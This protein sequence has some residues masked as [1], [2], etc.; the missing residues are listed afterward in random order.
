MY[1]MKPTWL[2]FDSNYLCWRAYHSTGQLS[3]GMIKTGI[4]FGYLKTFI[5]LQGTFLTSKVVHCFDSG[6]S[7][8]KEI[9]P[10][11]KKSRKGGDNSTDEEKELLGEVRKQIKLLRREYLPEIGSK[12]VFFQP[13]YEGDDVIA[14]VCQSLPEGSEAVIVS[15]DEDLFQLLSPTV[16]HF[17]PTTKKMITDELFKKEWGI[18]PSDWIMVKALAG[19]GSDEVIGIKG[20]GEKTAAKHIRGELKANSKVYGA[21]AK[22][23][24]V[25]QKNLPLVSLPFP[26]IQQFILQD[27]KIDKPGWESLTERLGMKSIK[28]LRSI[29]PFNTNI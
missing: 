22:Q 6:V 17:N 8:R 3:F 11:Y 15:A 25:V 20:V 21:I 13:G 4:V 24:D 29:L 10:G 19:C 9:C 5:D 27:D 28:N 14:S 26:G 7:L 23:L 2:L 12:N 18:N 16:S 1:A